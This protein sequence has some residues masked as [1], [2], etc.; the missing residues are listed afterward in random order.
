MVEDKH[1]N[2][3]KIYE[4]ARGFEISVPEGRIRKE[5]DEKEM[6]ELTESI[7]TFGQIQPGVCVRDEEI[8]GFSLVAGERR[9][10][11]CGRV[12]VKFQFVL[13]EDLK[14]GDR[15][16]K[17]IE[18]EEN[19]QREKLPFQNEADAID[20]LHTFMQEE[21]GESVEGVSGGHTIKDTADMLGKSRAIVSEDLELSM[22][23]K[24]YKEVSGARNKTEAK[25]AIKRIKEE[26]KRTKALDEALNRNGEEEKKE[27]GPKE[28]MKRRLLEYDKRCLEG[29]MED[30][31]PKLEGPFDLV[32]FDPPW[33]VDFDKVMYKH[34]GV[35]SYEDKSESF[36]E[37]LRNWLQLIWEKMA[38]DSHLY[39]FF[40][41]SKDS[42]G[43]EDQELSYFKEWYKRVPKRQFDNFDAS[44][45]CFMEG[46]RFSY[47]GFIYDIME[48]VGF[49][50]NR[51]PLIW[52]KRGARRTRNPDIWPGRSYEPIIYARKGKRVLNLKGASDVIRTPAPTPRIKADHPSAKHPQVYRELIE[53][54]AMPGDRVLDPTS[55]SGMAG[56]ACESLRAT[57]QL[58]WTMIEKDKKWR[59]LGL[60]NLHKGYEEI[61][62]DVR[63]IEEEAPVSKRETEAIK[64]DFRKLTPGSREWKAYWKQWPEDQKEMLRW[65]DKRKG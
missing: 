4:G 1:W 24:Y 7:K 48:K 20:E 42:Y 31:L 43:E 52:Y 30:L 49:E 5:F 44:Y 2:G 39:M 34:E 29:K 10:T 53:R 16:L 32:F 13:R 15:V 36:E 18:L 40:G 22:W 57:L 51:I 11:A 26:I 60:F 46:L 35:K 8:G 21:K 17:Q 23:G 12:G 45:S 41:M 62:G 3:A 61:V 54:S 37:S 64:G 25:K 56:V 59:D 14:K 33:G 9:L 38:K 55:G 6:K 28:R 65:K 19:I 63:E 58:D 47:G 50:T 27:E